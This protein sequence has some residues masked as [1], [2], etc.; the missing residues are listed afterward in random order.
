MVTRTW[1]QSASGYEGSLTLVSGAAG[2]GEWSER[3]EAKD[4][5]TTRYAAGNWNSQ[6]VGASC[7]VARYKRYRRF[8]MVTVG[9]A[10]FLCGCGVRSDRLSR[11]PLLLSFSHPTSNEREGEGRRV[12]FLILL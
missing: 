10:W 4:Q 11:G 9:L 1:L 8:S 3:A 12:G 6:E 5:I 2:E 7:C